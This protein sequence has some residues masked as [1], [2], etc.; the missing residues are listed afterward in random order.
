MIFQPMESLLDLIRNE[1]TQQYFITY[2]PAIIH[3][4]NA[5]PYSS[6]CSIDCSNIKSI[7][8]IS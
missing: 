8:S 4:S 5:V 1:T 2:L 7:F 3:C 6:P